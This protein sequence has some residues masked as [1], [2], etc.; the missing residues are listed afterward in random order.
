ML[1]MLAFH[2]VPSRFAP[3]LATMPF[4]ALVAYY[5]AWPYAGAEFIE[6]WQA[7]V[8]EVLA[9][10]YREPPP[11]FHFGAWRTVAITTPLVVSG[12]AALGVVQA[13]RW[14]V[15]RV[16]LRPLLVAFGAWLVVP[17]VRVTL[18]GLV[19]FDGI[20][21]FLE[22]WPPFA[23]FA[24]FGARFAIVSLQHAARRFGVARG[25]LPSRAIVLGV[26]LSLGLPPLLASVRTHPYQLTYFNA[27]V[28]GLGDAQAPARSTPR[29]TGRRATSRACVGSRLTPSAPDL[30]SCPW[31]PTSHSF[32]RSRCFRRTSACS[33]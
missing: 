16:E 29:T 4:V 17:L 23:V 20:R 21:H 14:W 15:R 7:H 24:L 5:F 2:R 28:G 26:L 19:D 9:Q 6:V 10:G 32:T 27:L 25:S 11:G 33:R 13:V 31:L 1:A 12:F 8:R 30:S 18:P 3:A 22:Y